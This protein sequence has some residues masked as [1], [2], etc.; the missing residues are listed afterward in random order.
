V[1]RVFSRLGR[2]A[3]AVASIAVHLS[4]AQAQHVP[5][6]Y[7]V[8]WAPD[9]GGPAT[10]ALV[11]KL[12][13]WKSKDKGA[14]NVR[15]FDVKAPADPPSGMAPILRERVSDAGVE[16]TWKYRGAESLAAASGTS[17]ICPLRAEA[18]RKD[19]MDVSVLS[20]GDVR[21]TFSR[22]CTSKAALKNA[23]PGSLAAKQKGCASTVLRRETKDGYKIEEWRLSS[24]QKFV[25]LSWVAADTPANLETFGKVVSRLIQEG[26]KPI[27]RSKT[28]IGTQCQ[29]Q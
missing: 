10:S 4:V 11:A 23:V 17:W 29:G 25:E 27:D 13:S 1:K 24:G 15:Y 14:V 2:R 18:K 26:A 3:W 21:R 16:V 8:R 20:T 22:S 19:E 9:E 5:A 6:E 28:D 7:A 12:M